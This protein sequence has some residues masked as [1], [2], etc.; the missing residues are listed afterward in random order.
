MLAAGSRRARRARWLTGVGAVAALMKRA[1]LLLALILAQVRPAHARRYAAGPRVECRHPAGLVTAR[2]LRER[3]RHGVAGIGLAH[4]REGAHVLVAERAHEGELEAAGA[5][6]AAARL[7]RGPVGGLDARIHSAARACRSA[8]HQRAVVEDPFRELPPSATHGSWG[9]KEH[10]P[11]R[12]H[13]PDRVLQMPT[14]Q[15]PGTTVPL[16]AAGSAGSAPSS[17]PL[18]VQQALPPPA[19]GSKLQ[20]A[21][22]W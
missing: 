19:H 14:A 8:A 21:P 3:G 6:R 12:Q 17:H 1:A 10:S 22:S 11:P 18:A 13:R 20:S 2:A 7:T 15:A 5:R 9:R 4:A 16:H